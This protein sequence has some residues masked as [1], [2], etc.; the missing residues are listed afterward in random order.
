MTRSHLSIRKCIFRVAQ[1]KVYYKMQRRGKFE[2]WAAAMQYYTGWECQKHGEQRPAG[3][4]ILRERSQL[5]SQKLQLLK[6]HGQPLKGILG[7]PLY[8]KNITV[9]PSVLTTVTTVTA[10]VVPVDEMG[11]LEKHGSGWL[12][13]GSFRSDPWE[14]I[15]QAADGWRWLRMTQTSLEAFLKRSEFHSYCPRHRVCSSWKEMKFPNML[16][17]REKRQMT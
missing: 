11:S 3:F 10:L 1:S 12:I 14:M 8:H 6:D 16:A 7:P 2:H 5:N 13:T 15:C 17:P 9:S 4:A